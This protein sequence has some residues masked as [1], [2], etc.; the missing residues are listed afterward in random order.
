LPQNRRVQIRTELST[1]NCDGFGVVESKIK[2]ATQ[3]VKLQDCLPPGYNYIH[4]PRY[5][6][7]AGGGL[8]FI[9]NENIYDVTK[10]PLRDINQTRIHVNTFESL[11]VKLNTKNAPIKSIL[12]VMIY[13]SCTKGDADDVF[14]N[15]IEQFITK[16]LTKYRNKVFFAGDFNIYINKN[17]QVAN[18]MRTIITRRLNMVQHVP[19][20]R[21][22]HIKG[23]TLDLLITPGTYQ[24]TNGVQIR[25]NV[26]S[27]DHYVV[28]CVWGEQ[29]PSK[30]PWRWPCLAAQKM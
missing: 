11:I 19:E 3:E 26:T 8:S 22:T 28:S 9:Y 16:S 20:T 1:H 6:K 24:P 12:V 10:E 2:T 27:S 15:Q 4:K 29:R 25:P 30:A 18:T 23:N 14:F 13:R 7:T 21:A 5:S 17:Y